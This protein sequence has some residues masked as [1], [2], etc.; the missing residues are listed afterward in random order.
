M[1]D[2][3]PFSFSQGINFIFSVDGQEI[4]VWIS[5]ISG[6]QK[7]YVN[8]QVVAQTRSLTMNSECVFQL[9]SQEYTVRVTS[10]SL[11][12]GPFYC[13]L[14]KSNQEIARKR[15]T[16]RADKSE[17]QNMPPIK[18]KWWQHLAVS[19]AI[20]AGIWAFQTYWDEYKIWFLTAGLLVVAS[21]VIIFLRKAAGSM[22]VIIEDEP[23]N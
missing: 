11:R 7:V 10:V 13:A 14:F 9:G 23:I 12:K 15:L 2:Y 22:Q 6:L 17:M 1:N 8:R 3:K 16:F 20:A 19:G 18:A 5:S 4:R 21:V